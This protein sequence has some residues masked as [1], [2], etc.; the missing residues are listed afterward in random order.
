MRMDGLL[1][2]GATLYAGISPGKSIWG[3]SMTEEVF[4][5]D[6]YRR[7]TE[8]K[9]TAVDAAGIRLDRTVFYPRGGGQAGDAGVLVL[10]NGAELAITDTVKG[11]APGEILHVPAPG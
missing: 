8:A 1:G 10:G 5:A 7:E 11:Q 2:I 6:A 9:V 3:H 4:R